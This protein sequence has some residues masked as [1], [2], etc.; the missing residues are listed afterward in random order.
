MS[1]QGTEE[2]DAQGS[3]GELEPAAE[4]GRAARVLLL[5]RERFD[6]AHVA[7]PAAAPA[8][9][10]LGGEADVLAEQELFLREYLARERPDTIARLS[11]PAAT[12]LVEVGVPV[13]REDLPRKLQHEAPVSFVCVVIPVQAERAPGG[14]PAR[15]QDA[16]VM[17]PAVG[18]TFYVERDEPLE[19]AI[20]HEVRRLLASQ[21]LGAW[22]HIGLLPGR[23]HRLEPRWIPLPELAAGGRGAPRR[24]EIAA[25]ALRKKAVVALSA[26]ATPLHL[27]SRRERP[28]LA[29]RDAEGARLAALLDGKERLGVLLVGPEHAGKS[30][31]VQ[32]YVGG[33]RRLVYATS[34]AQLIAGMSGL[35]EWQERI[36]DVMEAARELDAVLYLEN[37]EDLLAERV[38]AG[39][40]DLAGAMRPWIEDGKVRLVA[41][42]REDRLD[43]LE[44]RNW[45]FFAALSRIKV[46]PLTAAQTLEALERRAAHDARAEPHRPA[47]AASAL[48]ALVDLAE[49][50]LPY[51]AFPGKAAR[52]YEDMRAVREKEMTDRGAPVTIGR[53]DLY[54]AFSI[55][56]GVPAFLLRDDVPLRVEE[57]AAR[58]RKQIIG[59]EEAVLA[60]AQ[61]IGVVKAGLQPSGKPL[62]TFLFVGPTGVGKTELARAL[63]E[64]LFGSADRMARFDMSEFMTP[65]AADRLI[66]G[67]DREGGL[68]TMRVREQPFCVLLLDEIEKAH[69]S[70]FDLLLQVTGEGRL[71]DARGKTT[72]FHNAILIMTSNLGSAERRTQA[73]FGGGASTDAAHYRRIVDGAFRQELV[74]RIDRVVPFRSLSR[75]EVAAVA[76][77]A[78]DRVARRRGL[79]E[80][81]VTLEVS[82][83][84]LARIAADGYS[85]AYGARAMRR[86]VEEHVAA[87][88][89]RLLARLGGEAGDLAL[90]VT[91]AGEP[92]EEREEG[93]AREGPAVAS[94]ETPALRLSAR[95]R[96]TAK[97][98]RQAHGFEEISR[99]RRE[100]DAWT[101]LSPVEQLVD[102]IDFLRT[103]L[104]L[105]PAD[106]E[107]GRQAQETA[108][109][110]AE[111]HRLSEAWQRLQRAQEDVRSVEELAMMALFEGEAIG[112]FTD[113]ARAAWEA[114]RR[115]LP[116]ALVA[117]EPRR[118]AVTMV[119]EE[120]DEGAFDLWL[121]PMLRELPRRG[122][123]LTL[124]LDGD[125]AAPAG[126]VHAE[127]WPEARRWGPPRTADE[128]LVALAAPKR[129]FRSALLRAKGASAGVLLALEAGLHR[130]ALPKKGGDDAGDDRA[131]VFARLVALEGDITGEQ[132]DHRSLAPPH[133]SSA[134]TRRRGPAAR[135]HD[136]IEKVV[137][138]AGRRAR[139]DV[140]PGE[141]WA[142]LEEIALAHLLLFEEEGSGLSRDDAFLPSG[143]VG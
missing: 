22:D 90:R 88:L 57:V 60:L 50:Y 24:A 72:Y 46:E 91:E 93:A 28:P 59:Q 30:A 115:A 7:F 14:A 21:D 134:M 82:P 64:L 62:A 137:L 10:S 109:L 104:S 126:G 130:I 12:R 33:S 39:G 127:P 54:E 66:R 135:E 136:R 96:R 116:Y 118:D 117:Q 3:P 131:H 79:V 112:P 143:E 19:A 8:F 31:L 26:A 23:A 61:T 106:R 25:R 18:H 47:V 124:H 76:R 40:I 27:G 13:P 55:R 94:A 87:P 138:I 133:P 16:W 122:W 81:G 110:Q 51:G 17:V 52:L 111:H 140:D 80:A 37:L 100:V 83:R 43:A 38:E 120:L 77:L 97:A 68:L 119:L 65:D 32:A 86:H 6:G 105:G 1:E 74:N 41:E 108:Q 15:G 56:T 53:A 113:E 5:V 129:S 141:Y 36:R 114:Y 121:A 142:R 98:S 11:L 69:R 123:A 42:I 29:F 75:E 58:L 63:A 107:Q 45:A 44:G 92:E 89:A 99:L 102:Q 9:A 71:S 73:G 35:G 139:V 2:A 101:E 95:R 4:G 70:V 125:K 128:A 49:R 85:E 84:A 20:Q 103:Q 78:V 48:P 34:G 67:T 132:W